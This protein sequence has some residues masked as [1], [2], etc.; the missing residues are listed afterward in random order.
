M[1]YKV[2]ITSNAEEDL[3][4]FIDYLVNEKGS[5]QA[6]K[7]VIED[8]ADTVHCLATVANNLKLCDDPRLKKLGYRRM[9]FLRHRYFMMYRIVEDKAIVDNI[10]HSLQ[11]FESHMLG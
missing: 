3:D 6:A 1:E 8:F 2:V 7:N 4:S 5:I 10:F 11:D 9:N